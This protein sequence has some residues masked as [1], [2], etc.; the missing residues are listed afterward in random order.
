MTAALCVGATA[1]AADPITDAMQAAYGPYRMALYKTNGTSQSE[2]R[3]ALLQAQQGWEK[4]GAQFGAKPVAPY[5]R[6]PAFAA[7]VAEVGKVYAKA[8]DEINA[9]QLKAAHN[10]LE[11]ARDVMSAMRQRNQVVVF[12]DHMNAYHEVMEHLLDDGEAVLA[13]PKG[14]L[15]MASQTGAL[16]HLAKRLGSQAPASLS[17][18]PEFT[19]LLK[20][21]ETSVAQLEAAVLKEDASAVKEALGKLKGPYSKLFAKFG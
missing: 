5:D 21:V 3:E 12:S 17:T 8:L 15:L 18:N 14:L 20:A 9:N 6:D 11:H 13:K 10:T 19:T 7:S 1:W 4:L 16:A 2:S